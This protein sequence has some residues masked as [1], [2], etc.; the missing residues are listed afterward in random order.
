MARTK[1]YLERVRS[2]VVHVA[3]NVSASQQLK[4]QQNGLLPPDYPYA[5]LGDRKA[6]LQD[7]V[8]KLLD[9]ADALP[10]EELTVE[11]AAATPTK[12]EE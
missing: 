12:R 4:L 1:Q 9:R 8:I 3:V 10:L 11:V 2:G 7:V 5:P 6:M